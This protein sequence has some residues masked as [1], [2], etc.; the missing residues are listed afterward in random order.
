MSWYHKHTAVRSSSSTAPCRQVLWD[1]LLQQHAA[2][3]PRCAL[4]SRSCIFCA[5]LGRDAGRVPVPA[6]GGHHARYGAR[7][8]GQSWGAEAA[9]VSTRGVVLADLMPAGAS[10]HTSL[11]RPGGNRHGGGRGQDV[12]QG[13]ASPAL[14]GLIAEITSLGFIAVKQ[15]SVVPEMG[16]PLASLNLFRTQWNQSD[17]ACDEGPG[18]SYGFCWVTGMWCCGKCPAKQEGWP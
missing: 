4:M 1:I 11:L 2:G 13:A 14:S 18:A 16:L 8:G 17:A 3:R 12:A 15:M 9:V 7:S 10:P 5:H 6:A